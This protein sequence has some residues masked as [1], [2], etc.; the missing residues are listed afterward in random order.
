MIAAAIQ[1]PGRRTGT[2]LIA[3]GGPAGVSS[4]F[5]SVL[6]VWTAAGQRSSWS[7]R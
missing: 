5:V 7:R 3:A 6:D 2:A 1:R 4:P